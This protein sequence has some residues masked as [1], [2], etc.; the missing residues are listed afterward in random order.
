MDEEKEKA[1]FKVTDKRSFT[2]EGE[3]RKD[4]R[5]ESAKVVEFPQKEGEE[6]EPAPTESPGIDLNFSSFV[7]SMASSA[8][9]HLGEV[10]DPG[11]GKRES[12]LPAAKQMIDILGILQEKTR[13]NLTEDESAILEHLVY[14]LRLRYVE[15]VKK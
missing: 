5:A 2:A 6:K 13:G 10:A 4:A 8:M 15:R 9:V 12:N 11:T 3:L 1:T 7:L 14:D